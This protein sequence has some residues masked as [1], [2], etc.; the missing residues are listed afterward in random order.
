MI[1]YF[2]LHLKKIFFKYCQSIGD[3][4]NEIIEVMVFPDGLS[5]EFDQ[6]FKRIHANPSQILPPKN[7]G[8]TSKLIL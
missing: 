2:I 4:Q 3:R 7:G 8:N 1:L 5:G 6:T